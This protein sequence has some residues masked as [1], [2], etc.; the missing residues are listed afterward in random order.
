MRVTSD[1]L[2]K[3]GGDGRYAEAMKVQESIQRAALAQKSGRIEEAAQLYRDLL[4]IDPRQHVAWHALGLIEF[5]SGNKEQGIACLR[6]AVQ[7]CPAWPE[8]LYNLGTALQAAGM[9]TEAVNTFRGA[10]A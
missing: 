5:Q 6:Y 8:A 4:E 2:S 7:L 1:M 9:A 10:V 3:I